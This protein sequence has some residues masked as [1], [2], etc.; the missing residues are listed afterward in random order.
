MSKI[1]FCVSHK[2]L[3]SFS[4]SFFTMNVI[5]RACAPFQDILLE[6]E[7]SIFP[8]DGLWKTC[9]IMFLENWLEAKCE[10]EIVD[11]KVGEKQSLVLEKL[12][13]RKM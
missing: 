13:G 5:H 12:V 11:M 2:H 3:S 9:S 7:K 8:M 10:R 6:V 4:I 1:K